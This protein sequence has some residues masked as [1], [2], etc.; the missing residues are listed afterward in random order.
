MDN[1]FDKKNTDSQTG[2]LLVAPTALGQVGQIVNNVFLV[3]PRVYGVEFRYR[4]Q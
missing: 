2:T 1:V 3:N 4:F